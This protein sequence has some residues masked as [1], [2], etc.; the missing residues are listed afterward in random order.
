MVAS[1]DWLLNQA[2]ALDDEESR[3]EAWF[4][5]H[6]SVVEAGAETAPPEIRTVVEDHIAART[7][8]RG[9]APWASVPA[10]LLVAT[11]HVVW[12]GPSTPAALLAI[13]EALPWASRAISADATLLTALPTIARMAST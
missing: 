7:A 1:F 3:P 2:E 5:R 12:P 13:D 8:P 10:V 6:R 9:T 4:W 11:A